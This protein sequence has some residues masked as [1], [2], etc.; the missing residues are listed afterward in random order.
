MIEDIALQLQTTLTMGPRAFTK[1]RK[2][3]NGDGTIKYRVNTD[4]TVRISRSVYNA[5]CSLQQEQQIDNLERPFFILFDE[6]SL[7]AVDIVFGNTGDES[8]CEHD[9]SLVNKAKRAIDECTDSSLL[10]SCGHTHPV[11]YPTDSSGPFQGRNQSIR[12]FG[13]L[14]SNIFG[15]LP[16][17]QHLV[18]CAEGL[19]RAA[20]LRIIDSKWY[21]LYCEDYVESYYASHV[22][23]FNCSSGVLSSGFHWIFSPRLQQLGVF[24]VP[25][26]EVGVVVYY[27]WEI[28]D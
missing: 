21:K 26:D 11:F 16:T 6:T 22:P 27:F 19:Q 18:A 28:E 9:V 14:P 23:G 24:F 10:M 2:R 25:K 7:R 1:L 5:L 3:L 8:S 20:Y 17:W 15:D 13:A 12:A 4:R